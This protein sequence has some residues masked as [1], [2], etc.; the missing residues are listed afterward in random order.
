MDIANELATL[1]QIFALFL[2]LKNFYCCH[3]FLLS[4]C[5]CVTFTKIA[6]ILHILLV[7]IVYNCAPHSKVTTMHESR[8]LAIVVAAVDVFVCGF[9]LFECFRMNSKYTHTYYSHLNS[10]CLLFIIDFFSLLYLF[11][12]FIFPHS[13][14]FLSITTKNEK[15]NRQ[16]K[17]H[18][19]L[20]R[21]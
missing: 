20:C 3:L 16:I 1:K 13:P 6:P 2:Y 9:N 15:E 18:I 7:Y 8:L 12:S 14:I 10:K 19:N 17:K 5:L 21:I 11:T 4:H